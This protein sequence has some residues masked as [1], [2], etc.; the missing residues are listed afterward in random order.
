M[1]KVL[2]V[3]VLVM[4]VLVANAQATRTVVKVEDLQKTI[5][6]NIKAD[7][8]GY[9]VKDATKVTLNNVVTYEVSVVKGDVTEILVYDKDGKFIEKLAKPELPATPKET[10][11]MVKPVM[12]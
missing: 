1:K 6:D 11:P 8:I 9:T 7:F 4:A 5:V 10:M 2:F 3:L 12:E